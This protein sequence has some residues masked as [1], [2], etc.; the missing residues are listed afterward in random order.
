MFGW[1]GETMA[2]TS[3]CKR[4]G[5]RTALYINQSTTG[6]S[7]DK[8]LAFSWIFVSYWPDD[9]QILNPENLDQ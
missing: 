6:I 4:D 2:V 9:L 1:N 7:S 8:N 3:F 5:L